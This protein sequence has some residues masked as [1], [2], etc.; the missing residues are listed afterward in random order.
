MTRAIKPE[1][2]TEE[3]L[4]AQ[5]DGDL[6]F[7]ERGSHAVAAKRICGLCP[8]RQECLDYSIKNE[9]PKG[10]WGGVSPNKRMQ[11]IA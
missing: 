3:A 8:V 1:P 11:M 7:P 4:C 9:I 10:I 6:W 2:W 5:I